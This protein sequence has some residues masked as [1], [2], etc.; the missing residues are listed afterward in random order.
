MANGNVNLSLGKNAFTK[1]KGYN[2]VFENVQEVD[3]T[4]GFIDILVVQGTKGTATVSSIK[5]FCV[6]N[7]G[8]VPAEIQFKNMVWDNNS[9][10]DEV[11][12]ATN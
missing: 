7:I 3:N 9:N 5:A 2:Q 12:D 6:Y 1:A 4:D 11:S 10:V 8:D